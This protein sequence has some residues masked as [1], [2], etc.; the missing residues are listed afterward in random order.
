MIEVWDLYDDKK[1]LTHQ[2]HKRGYEDII[3][4]GMFHLAVEIWV[5]HNEK[6]LL[7]QR[8]PQKYHGLQWECSGGSVLQ[9]E[10]SL[11]GALRELHEEVGIKAKADE[12][13]YIGDTYHSDYIIDTY[14]YNQYIEIEDLVLQSEEVVNAKYVSFVEMQDMYNKNEIVESVWER[15]SHF[16]DR[17][18]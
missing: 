16:K 9:G 7:T 3:P 18:L 14:L 5:I 1:Q 15:F 17:L 6:I 8:H 11:H 2:Q 12:L 4:E 10:Q 13:L